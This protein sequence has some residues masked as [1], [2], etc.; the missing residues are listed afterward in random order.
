M[1]SDSLRSLLKT[2]RI[3]SYYVQN[4]FTGAEFAVG[5]L[6][7]PDR[8][9]AQAIA[10][11][12]GDKLRAVAPSLQ[13]RVSVNSAPKIPKPRPSAFKKGYIPVQER[14]TEE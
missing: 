9:Q 1:V 11:L 12:F 5:V 10:K 8:E 4:W 2:A 14:L 6:S 13:I 7:V 3:P